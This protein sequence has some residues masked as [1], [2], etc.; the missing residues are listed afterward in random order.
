MC[1]YRY[2]ECSILSRTGAAE[3]MMNDSIKRKVRG[4]RG[5]SDWSDDRVL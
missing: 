4:D 3:L 5:V 2:T 1:R